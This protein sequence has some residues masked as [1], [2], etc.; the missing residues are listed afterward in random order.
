MI[1]P[2]HVSRHARMRMR[3]RL[4]INKRACDREVAR[5]LRHGLRRR[6]LTGAVRRWVDNQRALHPGTRYVIMPNGIFVL[7]RDV[8]VTVISPPQGLRVHIVKAWT[9]KRVTSRN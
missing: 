7:G 9:R 1:L 3:Q 8:L 5:A 2:V 4:G 6:E